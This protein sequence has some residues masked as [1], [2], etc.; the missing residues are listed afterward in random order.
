MRKHF[1]LMHRY[2]LL[3]HKIEQCF[4]GNTSVHLIVYLLHNTKI[5]SESKDTGIKTQ[6]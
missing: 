2:R 4:A 1:I 5:V 3:F 6:P